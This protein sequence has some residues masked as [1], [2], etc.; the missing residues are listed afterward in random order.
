MLHTHAASTLEPAVVVYTDVPPSAVAALREGEARVDVHSDGPGSDTVTV[1]VLVEEVSLAWQL[2]VAPLVAALPGQHGP[3]GRMV[4]LAVVDAEPGAR[5][6]AEAMDCEQLAAELL[7]PVN[8][9]A[10]ALRGRLTPWL[11]EDVA[12]LLHDDA[13]EHAADRSPEQT[14]ASAVLGHYRGELDAEAASGRLVRGVEYGPDD[15]QV[16]LGALLSAALSTAVLV[17]GPAAVA[18]TT[19]TTGPFESEALRLLDELPAALEL[20][21]PPPRDA[22]ERAGRLLLSGTEREDT[23]RAAVSIV[24]RLARAAFGTE[25]ADAEVLRRLG[26]VDDAALAGLAELWLELAVASA[27]PTDGDAATAAA[28]GTR[29]ERGG[30]PAADWLARTAVSV[31]AAARAVAG[32]NAARIA[33]PLGVVDEHARRTG[34]PGGG[35]GAA[36]AGEVAR[37]CLVLARFARS[38]AGVGAG[39]WLELP[40]PTAAGAVGAALADGL[41]PGVGVELLLGLL[42]PDVGGPDLLDAL[43]CATAQLLALL[44]PTDDPEAA[45]RQAAALMAG[46]PAQGGHR[47]LLTGCLREAHAHDP[48]ALDLAPYLGAEPQPDLDRVAARTGPVGVLRD[49][50]AVL[51]TLT[52]TLGSEVGVQREDALRHV[53]PAALLEHDLL[54]RPQDG[55]EVD[56]P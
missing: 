31:A 47:W 24:A 30:G 5:F 14:L 28:L 12:V 55:T 3:D 26:M 8:E 54:R 18:E 7:L 25:L 27:G 39:A 29:V 11:A 48:A 15:F 52:A 38:R 41:D 56:G 6:F 53:L 33:G 23:V 19:A 1:R 44:E 13:H 16:A 40:T 9:L 17:A 49:G 10:E 2:P 42:A 45:A 4:L 20:G 37:A 22:A 50:L 51:E 35:L 46:V 43:V 34:E 21:G 32:R 36:A